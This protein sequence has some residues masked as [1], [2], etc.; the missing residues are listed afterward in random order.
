MYAGN[1]GELQ[2]L[3]P[4]IRAFTKAPDAQLV[5]LGDGVA[6]QRLQSMV[7][8]SGATNIGFRGPVPSEK[9]NAFIRASD[10][11]IVSLQDTPLLRAT[12][13]SKTQSS[14]AHGKP[15]LAHAA[16][17]LATLIRENHVGAVSPPGDLDAT[18]AAIGSL[19]TAGDDELSRM[20]TAAS[21]LFDERFSPEA[22]LDRIEAM[23]AKTDGHG[24]K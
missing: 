7:A 5:V 9:V 8:E 18:L 11:Q 13:P 20:G 4:L 6:R 21:R 22:G 15:V 10:V 23:L 16:G 14:L 12:M 24:R 17:D 19:V 3:D 1:V 2:G